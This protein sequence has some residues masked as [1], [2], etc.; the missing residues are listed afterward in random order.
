MSVPEPWEG[1]ETP[2]ELERARRGKWARFVRGCVASALLVCA[3]LI[4]Q[5]SPLLEMIGIKALYD[6]Y[7]LVLLAAPMWVVISW[8]VYLALSIPSFHR[9]LVAHEEAMAQMPPLDRERMM[10]ARF[11]AAMQEARVI[12]QQLPRARGKRK[13]N[14]GLLLFCVLMGG[15]AYSTVLSLFE[16]EASENSLMSLILLTPHIYGVACLWLLMHIWVSHQK[17]TEL[18]ARF[19]AHH[20]LKAD[21]VEVRRAALGDDIQGGLTP[22]TAR[23]DGLGDL[24]MH[25]PRGGKS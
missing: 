3:I 8:F 10:R 14:I 23:M 18:R 11:D 9:R 1:F 13:V 19:E 21:Y 16:R 25:A 2:G 24:E 17:L 12:E 6:R 15:T 7:L 20:K 4:M 22:V 5:R